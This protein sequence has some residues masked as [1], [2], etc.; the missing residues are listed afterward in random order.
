MNVQPD[1]P[2]P[3][4]GSSFTTKRYQ[5]FSALMTIDALYIPANCWTVSLKTALPLV[6][7]FKTFF[8]KFKFCEGSE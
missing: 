2:T 7:L 8:F 6:V 5:H 4:N 3:P 1:S